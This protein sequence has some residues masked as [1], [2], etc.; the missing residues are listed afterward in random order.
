[1][2][3]NKGIGIAS[4]K[5]DMWAFWKSQCVRFVASLSVI[6]V[7]KLTSRMIQNMVES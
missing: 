4:R 2:L 3:V 1:M 5:V 7:A 6:S